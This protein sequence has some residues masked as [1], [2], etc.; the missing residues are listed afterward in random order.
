ML[1]CITLTIALTAVGRGV[2]SYAQ[3]P[4]APSL[5]IEHV[6]QRLDNG[7]VAYLGTAGDGFSSASR[8]RLFSIVPSWPHNHLVE[9]VSANPWRRSHCCMA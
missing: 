7:L 4:A 1:G 5:G 8:K 2:G 6:G 3:K 9:G